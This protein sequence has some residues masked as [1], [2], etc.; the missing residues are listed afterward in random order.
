M[1]KGFGP[2]KGSTKSQDTSMPFTLLSNRYTAKKMENKRAHLMGQPSQQ[3]LVQ[4]VT[5]STNSLIVFNM[6][7]LQHSTSS[8]HSNTS[9]SSFYLLLTQVALFVAPTLGPDWSCWLVNVF[10]IRKD[11]RR[12]GK[13]KWG[14]YTLLITGKR[15]VIP[16]STLIP[17]NL[18][19]FHSL[20]SSLLLGNI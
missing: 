8:L 2:C 14:L 10:C 3:K 11:K 17:W 9:T 1:D 13:G 19:D 4:S 16:K 5:Q 12:Q 15:K 7:S 18:W 20:W 6:F